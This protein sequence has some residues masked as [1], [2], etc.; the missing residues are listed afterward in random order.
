MRVS[1]ID[2]IFMF[3]SDHVEIDV[4]DVNDF[5]P[6]WKELSYVAEAEEGHVYDEI[7]KLEAID[8]D[9]TEQ[10]SKICHYH[11]LTPD[12]PFD[13]SDNGFLRNTEPLVYEDKHNFILEV[14]AEDCGGR[15][16]EKL[17]V[18]ILVKAACKT[19]WKGEFE[20]STFVDKYLVNSSTL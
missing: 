18:N 7:V 5:A 8:G 2:V 15:T 11:L 17:L 16:T 3:V 12:V 13:I 1:E 9:G 10:N 14:K 19:G 20:A 4:E 6:T